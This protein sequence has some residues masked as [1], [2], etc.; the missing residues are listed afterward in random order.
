MYFDVIRPGVATMALLLISGCD[1]AK[2]PQKSA[3]TPAAT[4]SQS[5]LTTAHDEPKNAEGAAPMEEIYTPIVK[6]SAAE[7]ARH[8]LPAAEISFNAGDTSM[9]GWKFPAESE[10]MVLSGPPGGPLGLSVTHVA[11]APADAAGWQALVAKRYAD[12]TPEFGTDADVEVA[13]S[14]RPGYTFTTDKGFARSHHLMV[15]F[16]I[17]GSTEGI[18]L[19]YFED[20]GETETPTP[21]DM[22]GEARFADIR[23]SFS[24]QLENV[25]E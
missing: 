23:Q 7:S 17:A 24:V 5:S 13:G 11:T 3:E 16:K 1:A 19:D 2:E 10:Y 20:A 18:V 12:R 25:S 6:I 14:M 8:H 22:A 15:L 9:S 21:Q 4:E